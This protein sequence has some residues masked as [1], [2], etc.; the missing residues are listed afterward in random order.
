MLDGVE[1]VRVNLVDG[2]G[3][4]TFDPAKRPP[5]AVQ[6]A[7]ERAGYKVGRVAQ[8]APGAAPTVGASRAAGH[9]RTPASAKSSTISDEVEGLTHSRRGDGWPHVPSQ[10]AS[11]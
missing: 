9:P 1:S 2:E 4:V 11:T 6:A 5:R 3:P 8:A 7:V 10:S